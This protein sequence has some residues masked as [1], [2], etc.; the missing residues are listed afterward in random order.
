MTAPAQLPGY[1][2]RLYADNPDP[3]GFEG[4]PYEDA[5]Y[6][7][8]VA[9]LPRP[10][11]RSALEVGCSIGILTARIA[12]SC[13]ALLSTDVA[14]AALAS[15]ARRCADLPHVRFERSMLP[16]TPPAGRFDLIL[17]SEVLYYFDRD[18]LVQVAHALASVADPGADLVLVHWLG[19]TPDYP[20]TGDQAVDVFETSLP[21]AIVMA[22]DRQDGYRLDVLRIAPAG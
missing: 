11:Y 18:A 19:P 17:L 1:F 21:G 15:A 8:T 4:N 12:P 10:R 22:R 14:D 9:A 3:W 16:G 13:D 20:L 5:K 6:T 7:A 2:D